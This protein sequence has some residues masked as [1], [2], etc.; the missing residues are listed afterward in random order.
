[1]EHPIINGTLVMSVSAYH[2]YGKPGNSRENS[3]G[4]VHPGGNYPEK[5]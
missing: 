3:N 4:T 5:K 2:L 1:M